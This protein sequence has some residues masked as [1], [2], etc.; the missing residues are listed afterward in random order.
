LDT[1]EKTHTG[2]EVESS[3]VFLN[4]IN[5]NMHNFKQTKFNFTAIAYTGYAKIQSS[6]Q[7]RNNFKNFL[8]DISMCDFEYQSILIIPASCYK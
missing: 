7:E 1:Q 8:S 5:N 6:K 4:F 3:V 2:K